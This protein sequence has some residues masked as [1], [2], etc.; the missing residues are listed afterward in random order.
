VSDGSRDWFQPFLPSR[1]YDVTQPALEL[2]DFLAALVKHL[3]AHPHL[4]PVTVY[5]AQG[6]GELYLGHGDEAEGLHAWFSSLDEA[7]VL[8][9]PWFG[10]PRDAY[11][12]V[13]GITKPGVG[14]WVWTQVPGLGVALGYDADTPLELE[15]IDDSVLVDFALTYDSKDAA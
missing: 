6:N 12:R 4:P 5:S 7:E 3:R 13:R 11:V 9:H 10:A 14:V 2:A 8:A 1:G 15:P